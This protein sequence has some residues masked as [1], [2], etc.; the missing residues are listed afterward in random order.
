ME[1]F[2]KIKKSH[3]SGVYILLKVKLILPLGI[4]PPMRVDPNWSCFVPEAFQEWKESLRLFSINADHVAS[5]EMHK[6][7]ILST[8]LKKHNWRSLLVEV[9]E[10]VEWC[11]IV[12][13][14]TTETAQNSTSHWL[15]DEWWASTVLQNYS[16][17]RSTLPSLKSYLYCLFHKKIL[18]CLKDVV[19]VLG[20]F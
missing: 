7:V 1:E 20:C 18:L 6:N 19:L 14:Q 2:N 17:N 12:R 9:N 5:R 15:G 10:W 4:Q 16:S 8:F 3:R 13:I 11:Q